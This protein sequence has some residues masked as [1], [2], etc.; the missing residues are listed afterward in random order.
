MG[1]SE[2]MQEK[3]RAA[4]KKLVLPE[5]D[6]PRTV[7]AAKIII[8]KKIAKEVFLVGKPEAIKKTASETGTDLSGVTL[9]EPTASP[10]LAEFAEKYFEL[11]K[12][13]GVDQAKAKEMI[14][15]NL[16]WGAMMVR[17]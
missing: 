15:D 6:E 11:R 13:K 9:V 3:A 5:G 4:Q 1:F 2:M 12:H 17:T 10:L 14:T 7:Q 16:R 8:D